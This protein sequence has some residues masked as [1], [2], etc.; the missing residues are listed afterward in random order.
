[1]KTT[2]ILQ[3]EDFV[4]GGEAF[5]PVLSMLWI[6]SYLDQG[7]GKQIGRIDML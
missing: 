4:L 2:A 5:N 6:T 7:L 3:L 1:M